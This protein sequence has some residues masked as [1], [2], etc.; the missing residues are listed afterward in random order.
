[1]KIIEELKKA[2]YAKYQ[3]STMYTSDGVQMYLDH[4]PSSVCYPI[5]CVYHISS[6]NF[7]SMPTQTVAGGFDYVDSRWQMSVYSNDRQHVQIEDLADRLEDL[8]HRQPLTLA[9]NCT[10]IATISTDQKTLFYD[11]QQKIWTIR[12]D[13]RILAGK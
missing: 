1:M 10:H 5:I 3:T 11:Q 8:F 13:F 4:V 7:M 6:N 12:L 9:N 2:I